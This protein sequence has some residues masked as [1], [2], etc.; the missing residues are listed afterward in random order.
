[1]V[2][3]DWGW[4]SIRRCDP[5]EWDGAHEVAGCHAFALPECC[6]CLSLW[7]VALD[8]LSQ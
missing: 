8:H 7:L 6:P 1:M 2:V 4:E 5:E 3:D